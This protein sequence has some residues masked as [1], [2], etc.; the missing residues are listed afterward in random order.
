MIMKTTT[1]ATEKTAPK[2]EIMFRITKTGKKRAYRL[3]RIWWRWFPMPLA[4]A[5]LLL[6]TD[7]AILN[8]NPIVRCG[9]K[10]QP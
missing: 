2:L 9:K 6:A 4:E 1:N 3:E 10:V 5:E 8:E 7:R